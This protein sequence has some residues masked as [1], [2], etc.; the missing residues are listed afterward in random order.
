MPRLVKCPSNFCHN[1][2]LHLAETPACFLISGY[3]TSICS[4][5]LNAKVPIRSTRVMACCENN[6][7]NGFVFPDYT[8]NRWRGHDPML[9]ND[10]TAH[11]RKCHTGVCEWVGGHVSVSE[12]IQVGVGEIIQQ[13]IRFCVQCFIYT[14]TQR[15]E[16]HL[17]GC[18]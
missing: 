10:Q 14:L 17:M 7:A 3:H 9:S 13:N 5:E 11:L 4:I 15:L 6:A 1:T 18:S 2:I 12:Y 8:G 16:F